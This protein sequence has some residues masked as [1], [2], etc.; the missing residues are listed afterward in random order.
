[1]GGVNAAETTVLCCSLLR[2]ATRSELWRRAPMKTGEE[3]DTE[4][5]QIRESDDDQPGLFMGE[6]KASVI[7]DICVC[8]HCATAFLFA[9]VMLTYPTVFSLF[10]DSAL[11]SLAQ[12]SI[13]W[14]SPF[15]FGFSW[16]AAMSLYMQPKDRIRVATMYSG[17]FVLATGI[18]CAVQAT[19]RWR[20][21][22]VLNIVLFAS[23]A[24]MYGVFVIFYK[25]AFHRSP[26][27]WL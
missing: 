15:V 4:E 9:T 5:L 23:L 21:T 11:P 1:M 27:S 12:D 10:S 14:A 8:S 22:H 6:Q 13:R 19:G 16:L 17:S 25:D 24:I 7:L 18:G 3:A 26:K 20:T 2:D